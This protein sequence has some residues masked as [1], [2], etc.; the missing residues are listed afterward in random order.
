MATLPYSPPLSVLM[1]VSVLLAIRNAVKEARVEQL[2][3]D[4]D[5]WFKIGERRSNKSLTKILGMSRT[6]NSGNL[7]S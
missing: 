4:R 1:G 3:E 6:P 2:A 5:V 7:N